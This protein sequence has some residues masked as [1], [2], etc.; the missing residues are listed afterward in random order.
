MKPSNLRL[1]KVTVNSSLVDQIEYNCTQLTMKVKF[2]RGKRS[3]R[4][5]SYDDISLS[6]FENI[7]ASESVGKAILKLA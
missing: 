5:H 1:L 2:K 7:L 3:R 6:Q 4:I